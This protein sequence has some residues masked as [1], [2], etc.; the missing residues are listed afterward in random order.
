[1]LFPSVLTVYSQ[2]NNIFFCLLMRP[3]RSFMIP[4]LG[5]LKKLLNFLA[6][7]VDLHESRIIFSI[8]I[9][10]ILLSCPA[11]KKGTLE[12]FSKTKE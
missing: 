10:Y 4:E 6:L 1:M 8:I 5:Q 11:F 7:H 9:R 12:E 3:A 2:K